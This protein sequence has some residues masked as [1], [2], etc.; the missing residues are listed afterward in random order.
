MPQRL[1]IGVVKADNV[2]QTIRVE[3]ERV[4]QNAKYGKY[5]RR[6][7]VCHVHDE[8]DEAKLGDTVEIRE[9]PPRSKLK[10]WELVRIVAQSR[11]VD[12]AA[13]KAVQ[14]AAAAAGKAP[15]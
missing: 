13:L 2:P 1:V 6:K 15:A 11:L 7:T 9:C 8:K 3:I 4:V 12:L 14:D 10:H 5:L